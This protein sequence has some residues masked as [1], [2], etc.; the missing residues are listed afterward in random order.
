MSTILLLSHGKFLY[1]D[2]PAILG[3]P[4]AGLKVVHVTTAGKG[5]S[6]DMSPYWQTVH[7]A[8]HSY[9]CLVEDL[10]IE[11]HSEDELRQ[12]LSAADIVFVNGGNVF[13]LLRAIRNSGFDKLIKELLPQGLIY[14]GASAGAYVACPTVEAGTWKR[15]KNNFG[16]TDLQAM[17]LVPFLMMAHYLPE[18]QALIADK[19]ATCGREV[20]VMSDEQAILI[21]DDKI[22]MLGY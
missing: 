7:E 10:D 4:L 14:M 15:A 2:L 1:H 9:D 12:I 8:F 17:S 3:R 19:A 16:V 5:A 21:K 13:Y 6:T 18:H 20:K 22:E 11:G